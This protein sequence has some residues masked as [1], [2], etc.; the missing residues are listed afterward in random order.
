MDWCCN[1]SLFFVRRENT[2]H[3][4]ENNFCAFVRENTVKL[5]LSQTRYGTL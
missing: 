5:P 1:F 2:I 3:V 4:P